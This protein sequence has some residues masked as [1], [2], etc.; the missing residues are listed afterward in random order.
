MTLLVFKY[1]LKLIFV[2]MY[3][4]MKY[5]QNRIRRL[6]FFC[7]VIEIVANVVCL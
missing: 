2:F 4:I 3:E 6:I 5:R 7:S 1:I